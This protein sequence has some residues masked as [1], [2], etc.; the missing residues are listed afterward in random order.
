MDQETSTLS[1]AQVSPVDETDKLTIYA[2][3]IR[4]K[5]DF[6]KSLRYKANTRLKRKHVLSLY[7]TSI[8]SIYVIGASIAPLYLDYLD[9]NM[10]AIFS[11]MVSIFII[12]ITLIESGN[13]YKSTSDMLMK[14]ARRLTILIQELD[15]LI[16]SEKIDEKGLAVVQAEYHKILN[17]FSVNHG[18]VDLK[19]ILSTKQLRRKI[20]NQTM[21]ER[22]K[23]IVNL[24]YQSTNYQL[25]IY[26]FYF[27][28]LALPILLLYLL[29]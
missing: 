11:I 9:K 24:I 12:V 8:L 26:L 3:K 21:R 10:L 16:A 13:N 5:I 25:N 23:L 29:S 19:I 15:L 7:T 14:C 20:P 1:E 4:E 28:L 27:T 2:L 17:E 6:T 22:F 18:D